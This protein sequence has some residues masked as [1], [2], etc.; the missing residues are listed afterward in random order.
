MRFH[1]LDS[2]NGWISL[3]ASKGAVVSRLSL[4][5]VQQILR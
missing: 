3:M 2:R 4:S 5:A 1:L